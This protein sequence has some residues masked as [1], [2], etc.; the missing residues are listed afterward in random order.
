MLSKIWCLAYVEN[1][2]ADIIQNIANDTYDFAS[3]ELW[4]SQSKQ[5]FHYAAY[6]N[7]FVNAYMLAIM[8]IETQCE[9]IHC[10]ILAKFIKGKNENKTRADLMLR[11]T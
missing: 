10:S 2:P 8:D 9:T 6:R 1:P 5:K 4:N 11:Q 7:G 3:L